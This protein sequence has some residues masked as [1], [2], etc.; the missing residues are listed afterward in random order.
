MESIS[1]PALGP[2]PRSGRPDPVPARLYFGNDQFDTVRRG[3]AKAARALDGFQALQNPKQRYALFKHPGHVEG[4][5]R[6]PVGASEKWGPPSVTSGGCAGTGT[7][8]AGIRSGRRAWRL[9][10]GGSDRRNKA[11][12]QCQ[13][14]SHAGDSHGASCGS[15]CLSADIGLQRGNQVVGCSEIAGRGGGPRLL[16]MLARLP[17]PRRRQHSAAPLKLC[18]ARRA[19][20]R[21]G[22][23][24]FAK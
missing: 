11:R 16:E 21:R 24:R 17:R 20:T 8:R 14:R 18:A 23:Q 13:I 5:R 7:L 22:C 15:D 19:F 10:I 12:S 9:E 3:G 6:G 2:I 4:I 1:S